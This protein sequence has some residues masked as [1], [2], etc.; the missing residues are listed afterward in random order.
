MQFKSRLLSLLVLISA[1]IFQ[2]CTDERND[3][4]EQTARVQVKLVDLPG[5]YLEVNVNI[6][7][8]L[9][10]IS[11]EDEETG[12]T[13]FDSFEQGEPVDLTDLTGGVSLILADEVLPAGFLSQIRLVLDDNGNTI[14]VEGETEGVGTE[15]PLET[16]SAQQSGLKIQINEEL[17]GGF[18]YNIV[19][20]WDVQ[21][22][23]VETGS[24]K[25]QLKP[26]IRAELEANSGVISGNVFG[27]LPDDSDENPVAL[28]NVVVNLY[29][30]SQDL[31][32]E[33]YTSTTTDETGHY[34]L[35][36]LKPGIYIIVIE[37]EGFEQFIST[38]ITVRAGEETDNGTI[39]LVPSV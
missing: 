8:V 28:E 7:D 39:T 38:E 20:D 36:G 5:D 26:V 3:D 23:V 18:S 21:K 12:W 14:V 37:R 4:P 19:L 27:D 2:S 15:Y 16:P 32:E 31:S 6:V 24:D 35:E 13:N 10:K 25:Y 11:D 22:S 9:Y 1:F 29:E 17:Q 34:W 30:G 33:P